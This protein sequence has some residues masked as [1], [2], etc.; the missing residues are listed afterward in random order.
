MIN[1]DGYR[2]IPNRLGWGV[3]L[4][5]EAFD[6]MPARSMAPRHELPLRWLALLSLETVAGTA[7]VQ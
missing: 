1:N 3:E 4:N 7:Q 6:G 5:E 2:D